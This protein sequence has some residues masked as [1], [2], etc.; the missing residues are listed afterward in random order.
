MPASSSSSL[1]LDRE[2]DGPDNPDTRF[3]E[4]VDAEIDELETTTSEPSLEAESSDGLPRS[5]DQD[6]RT[7]YSTTSTPSA[8]LPP[9]TNTTSDR[10][11]D[12]IM[13]PPSTQ[14]AR[15]HPPTLSKRA[16]KQGEALDKHL[17]SLR[18]S[19]RANLSHLPPAQQRAL[20]LSQLGQLE[21]AKRA[22]NHQRGNLESKGNLFGC[23]RKTFLVRVPPHFG[24]VRSL[25]H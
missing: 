15:S 12:S 2:A 25:K 1:P 7:L 3:E 11:T 14:P 8:R 24:N 18:A 10:S 13:V 4:D 6:A 21:N 20:L 22:E 23:Q 17:S 16:M 5:V 9:D 19:D